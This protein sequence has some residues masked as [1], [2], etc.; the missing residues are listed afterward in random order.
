[1]KPDLKTEFVRADLDGVPYEIELIHPDK[2]S[3][4]TV[5]VTLQGHRKKR[6]PRQHSWDTRDEALAEAMKIVREIIAS[7][8]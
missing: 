5:T 6:G 8:N 2:W 3:V 4:Q 1:M 7:K